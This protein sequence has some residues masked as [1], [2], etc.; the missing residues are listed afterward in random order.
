MQTGQSLPQVPN[1]QL[2]MPSFQPYQPT[3]QANT[4]TPMQLTMPQVGQGVGYNPTPVT[5]DY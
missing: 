2:T 1:M 3:A 4:G 5:I